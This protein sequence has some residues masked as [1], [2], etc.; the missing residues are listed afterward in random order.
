MRFVVTTLIVVAVAAVAAA[1]EPAAARDP[2][3]V[4]EWGTF[5]SVQG[6]DGVALEG[7]ATEEEA[8]PPFVY[9]RTKV[10]ECPLRAKGYKG[11]E[12]PATHVTQKMETPVLYFR[13]KT[14][15]RVR[16]RVDFVG[17]LI[18]QW[19]PV[20]DLVGPPEGALADGPL[21]LSK[22]KSSF[23]QWDVE[24][25]PTLDHPQR[26]LPSVAADDPWTFARDVDCA[27]V[28]TLPRKGADR[29]GPVETEKFLF[30]RGLGTFNLPMTVEAGKGGVVRFKNGGAAA[31]P[32]VFL[33]EM[34]EEQ[35]RLLDLGAVPAGA[36]ATGPL[37]KE[38]FAPKAAVCERLKTLMRTALVGEKLA[39]DEAA[40]MVA[41]WAR[42]WFASEGTRVLYVVPRATTDALLPLAID[43][44]PDELVRV[45]VGRL[46][47]LTPETEAEVAQA[48]A[49][50][51]ADDAPTRAAAE[52]RLNR[53]GRFLEPHARRV[54]A[55][56]ADPKV[57]AAAAAVLA[58]LAGH[59]V[60]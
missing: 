26:S 19:Y 55:V 3:V 14:P 58:E 9:S 11:L 60:R 6:S 35:G 51:T 23:L 5:T 56:T 42:Q 49:A 43:P 13:S 41:T 22:I 53:L 12:V 40:A 25:L 48:L 30:Y 20:S 2:F 24:L 59:V 32:R 57:R 36:A 37:A 28:R 44:K 10:R 52:A 33:V 16:V 4:H 34:K 21:D 17:G 39:E 27:Y 46:E 31:L 18:T 38:A 50:R 54:A 45:L 7:L 1:Q 15:R 8:L 29:S 47:Y